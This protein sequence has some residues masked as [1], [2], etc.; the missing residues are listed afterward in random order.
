MYIQWIRGYLAWKIHIHVYG[1][2]KFGRYLVDK[3]GWIEKRVD[4]PLT[5]TGRRVEGNHRRM[6]PTPTQRSV[7][8]SRT[9]LFRLCFTAQPFLA[10]GKMKVSISVAATG[11]ILW[12]YQISP[13]SYYFSCIGSSA[14]YTSTFRC[15]GKPPIATYDSLQVHSKHN[16]HEALD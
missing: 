10:F 16:G 9:T 12:A 8:I 3:M 6:V 5:I 13:T 7:Q 14:F 1:T 11:N 4:R 2:A 15:D